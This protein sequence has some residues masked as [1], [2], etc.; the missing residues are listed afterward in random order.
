MAALLYWSIM[1]RLEM[2]C[3]DSSVAEKGGQAKLPSMLLQRSPVAPGS[4]KT[5]GFVLCR[6]SAQL[7]H[8]SPLPEGD[9]LQQGCEGERLKWPRSQQP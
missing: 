2:K 4:Y 5:L 9:S 8:F 6:V 1:V 7:K 3:K